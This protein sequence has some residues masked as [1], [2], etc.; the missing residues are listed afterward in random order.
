MTIIPVILSGGAGTR[1]WP[2]S[3]EARPKQFLPLNADSHLT[4]LQETAERVH[5]DDFEAPMVICAEQHRFLVAEQMREIGIVPQSIILE[6]VGR[7][8]A[9]AVCVAALQALA[10]DENTTLLVLPA[11]HFIDDPARFRAVVLSAMEMAGAGKLVTFGVPAREPNTGFG[12]IFE[13]ARIGRKTETRVSTIASFVEK[14]NRERA[15]AFVRDGGY[16]WNSG[17][18]LFGARCIVDEIQRHAPAVQKDV[19]LALASAAADLDF[20]RLDHKSFSAIK[21]ISIDHAVME[22]TDRGVVATLDVGWSDL[23]SWQA[24]WDI[25]SKDSDGNMV[26]GNVH[27]HDVRDSVVRSDSMFVVASRV[28]DLIIIV[29]DDVVLVMPRSRAEEVK[30]IVSTL[31]AAKRKEATNHPL[32]FRPWGTY[33]SVDSAEKFLVKRLTIK[34]GAKLSLQKHKHRAEHWVVV[35]GTARITRGDDVFD[36]VADQSTYIPLGTVHRLENPGDEPLELIEVQTG[37]YIG[38]DDIVRLEDSYG[39]S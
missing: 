8:T 36:L 12:Y 19:A 2:L 18:F 39:R 5:T 24:L 22:H 37:S 10:Q 28:E 35:R 27:L 7:N 6:P 9:P 21:P 30:A 33:R 26:S 16:L 31:A 32:V 20:L 11:D 15:E 1:L 3:R 17:I 25:G 29:D 14:P 4:L 34:P 13:G 23:G 38:E